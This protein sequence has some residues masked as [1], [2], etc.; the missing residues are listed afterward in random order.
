MSGKILDIKQ[1]QDL[2]HLSE[3]T[4]FRLIK[5]GELRGFKAGREWRFEESD[6][7]DFIQ[8]Q[9]EKAIQEREKKSAEEVVQARADDIPAKNTPSAPTQS[10][11]E[12]NM[13]GSHVMLSNKKH[14]VVAIKR[15]TRCIF[16]RR[17]ST[18]FSIAY[19]RAYFQEDHSTDEVIPSLIRVE[20]VAR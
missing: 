19:S 10:R 5:S 1:V 7:Q 15:A 17:N 3:R 16:N 11:E 2:L 12:P 14:P 8:K 6:I 4:V 20:E 18:M 13:H 9:K